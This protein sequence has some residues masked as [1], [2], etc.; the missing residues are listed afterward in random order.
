M[1]YLFQDGGKPKKAKTTK[2]KTP[3]K[4]GNS[5]GSNSKKGE[6]NGGAEKNPVEKYKAALERRN[7][8]LTNNRRAAFHYL[9]STLYLPGKPAPQT[10]DINEMLNNIQQNVLKETLDQNLETWERILRNSSAQTNHFKTQEIQNHLKE[11]ENKYIKRLMKY[12]K[13]SENEAVKMIR[14]KKMNIVGEIPPKTKNDFLKN[15]KNILQ[16]KKNLE[17]PYWKIQEDLDTDKRY[18]NYLVKHLKINLDEAKQIIKKE[19]NDF[20]HHEFYYPPNF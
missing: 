14:G 13:V 18:V 4:G 16:K 5:L 7:L 10:K 19:K 11:T 8:D 12:H 9:A 2:S 20:F 1:D 6:M 15:Y 17:D 3:K